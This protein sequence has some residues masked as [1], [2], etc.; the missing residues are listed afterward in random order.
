[1]LKSALKNA[2]IEK[3]GVT[4]QLDDAE[5]MAVVRKQ[6]KQRQDSIEGFEKGGR[7]ELAAKE[8]EEFEILSQYL[9][10]QLGRRGNHETGGGGHRRSGSHFQGAN[11]RGDEDRAGESGGTGG[12]EGAEPGSA[13]AVDMKSS[14]KSENSKSEIRH[15]ET[16]MDL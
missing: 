11:G 2:A 9:P 6:V 3:Y 7:P 16:Q 4:G 15:L 8:K 1:M 14:R 5:A 13:E 10:K 12:W